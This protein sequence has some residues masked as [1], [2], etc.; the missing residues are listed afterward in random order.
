MIKATT[1]PHLLTPYSSPS[2][3]ANRFSASQK[4][5]RILWKPKVH[6]RVHNRQ[7]SVPILR[8]M[9]PVHASHLT[10]WRS[11][12]ILSS[13]LRLGFPSFLFPSG[14][15]HQTLY[16]PLISTIRA[17]NRAHPILL[18]LITRKVLRGKYRSLSSSPRPLYPRQRP[19]THCTGG[20]VVPSAGL[21][22]CGKSRLHRPSWYSESLYP[23]RPLDPR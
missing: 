4:I 22:G 16:T 3:E 14:P 15:P 6:Y 19:G 21:D 23:L 1:R 17:T 13:H 7:P 5:P 18:D 11:V 8:Q 9:N 12:L 10:S 20:W 2:W